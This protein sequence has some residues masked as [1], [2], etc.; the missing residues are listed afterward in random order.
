MMV[1]CDHVTSSQV[2]NDFNYPCMI[3]SVKNNKKHKDSLILCACMTTQNI[4]RCAQ[5]PNIMNI[6]QNLC[7]SAT[8]RSYHIGSLT[9]L[10]FY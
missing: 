3:A 9:N 5:Y 10:S 2:N 4:A 6:F 7:I 8:E 1:M